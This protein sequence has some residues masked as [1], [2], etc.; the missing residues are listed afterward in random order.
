MKKS[1][2]PPIIKPSYHP[3]LS[4]LRKEIDIV[5]RNIWSLLSKR[6]ALTKQVAKIKQKLG[7]AVY[8]AAREK[9]VLDKIG[10]RDFDPD[11]T[12]AISKLYKSLFGISKN[13]QQPYTKS[14]AR[15]VSTKKPPSTK[16]ISKR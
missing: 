6:F 10:A 7:I 14:I 13:Y 1:V 4:K 12:H 11:V 8:D 3:A 5:D 9:A 16:K 15:K 2:C